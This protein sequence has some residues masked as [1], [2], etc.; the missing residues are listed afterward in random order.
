VT[1]RILILLVVAALTSACRVDGTE[2][3]RGASIV[4]AWRS[5]V[6]IRSGAFASMK[7][8]EFLYA[9]QAG[10][11]MTESSNYDAA[12]PVPPAY[13]VWRQ[14]GG[15]RFEARY[16]FFTTRAL[17]PEE[18]TGA[19]GG[20]MPS[21]R[22]VFDESIELSADGSS[23]TSTLRYELFDPEGEAVEGG[24]SGVGRGKRLR[25]PGS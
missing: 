19:G 4:G 12:P 7:G 11:T 22:G 5:S 15:N 6:E 25:P 2:T 20:W 23:F 3:T 9:F 16:E 1:A 10:G 18:A 13:G 24:G 14:V 21:G 17:T 8:L